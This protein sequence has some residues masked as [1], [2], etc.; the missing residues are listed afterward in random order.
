MVLLL[1]L[2]SLLC[3]EVCPFIPSVLVVVFACSNL[4]GCCFFLMYPDVL[5]Q[6]CFMLVGV[7]MVLCYTCFASASVSCVF[8]CLLCMLFLLV[9]VCVFR[10]GLLV[11]LSFC[12]QFSCAHVFCLICLHVHGSPWREIRVRFA[13]AHGKLTQYKAALFGNRS[14][15][16]E[17]K[18][19]LFDS[20]VLSAL[21]YNLVIWKP[22][23]KVAQQ[24][25]ERKFWV[26]F[27]EWHSCIMVSR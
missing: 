3:K 18:I 12:G 11:C 24:N 27:V 17:K 2:G 4:F 16:K 26:W 7:L 10:Y 13:T 20:L 22:F 9:C 21:M 14:F 1:V 8:V 19:Q 5:M 25:F 23:T 6:M 15:P